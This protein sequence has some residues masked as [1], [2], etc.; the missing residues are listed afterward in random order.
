MFHLGNQFPPLEFVSFF[1]TLGFVCIHLFINFELLPRTAEVDLLHNLNQTKFKNS[2]HYKCKR[3]KMNS[4]YPSV[5]VGLQSRTGLKCSFYYI[6]SV[7]CWSYEKKKASK[8]LVSI[9]PGNS[10]L[11]A[12]VS[13]A[14]YQLTKLDPAR[15]SQQCF[16]GKRISLN[17]LI[18]T[19]DW[20]SGAVWGCSLAQN[21]TATAI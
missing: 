16:P 21:F 10:L 18:I 13:E 17:Q 12:I 14:T 8:C 5:W 6:S 2:N 4:Y 7:H 1:F 11:H 19:A 9:I 15:K 20:M 3:M